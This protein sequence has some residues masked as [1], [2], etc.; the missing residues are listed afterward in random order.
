MLLKK[1]TTNS[2]IALTLTEKSTLS[3]PIYLFEFINGLQKVS[4]TCICADSATATQKARVN[5]FNIIGR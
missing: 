2:D 5:L 4:Y 3:E 1:S